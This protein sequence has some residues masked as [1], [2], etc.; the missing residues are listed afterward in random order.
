MYS[1]KVTEGERER[2]RKRERT[3]ERKRERE[4]KRRERSRKGWGR[5]GTKKYGRREVTVRERY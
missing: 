3:R 4:R 2:E 5:R 1:R